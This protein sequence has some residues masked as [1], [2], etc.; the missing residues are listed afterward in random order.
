LR[1][2]RRACA[3]SDETQGGRKAALP[4]GQLA[5]IS[6]SWRQRLTYGAMSAFVVWHTL[7][8]VIAPA[9]DRSP[10]A[11]ALRG[12]VQPYLSLFRLDNLWDFFAPNVN[13]LSDLHYVIEDAAGKEHRFAPGADLKWYY[14]T[15]I[16]FKAWFYAVMENPE[17]YADS[18]GAIFCRQHADLKPVAV[19]LL[20]YQEGAIGP[21]DHLSGKHPL[22]EEFVTVNTVKRVPCPEPRP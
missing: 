13:R 12:V 3:A 5:M 2:F 20:E 22:D 10:S 15:S 18:A 21:D 7:A 11:Q 4:F 16:W 9:P 14:P 1:E 19:T 8:M 6:K 17:L